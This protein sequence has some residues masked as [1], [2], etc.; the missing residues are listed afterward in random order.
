MK[1]STVSKA[2]CNSSQNPEARIAKKDWSRQ[3][4]R[5]QRRRT[6]RFWATRLM[7]GKRC[8][9][10]KAYR[11]ETGPWP[12]Y[13]GTQGP[14]KGKASRSR[15]SSRKRQSRPL[16]LSRFQSSGFRPEGKTASTRHGPGEALGLQ[17]LASRQ[18]TTGSPNSPGRLRPLS[19]TRHENPSA[20]SANIPSLKT[21]C[22]SRRQPYTESKGPTGWATKRRS[23]GADD[24]KTGQSVSASS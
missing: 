20:P 24:I 21:G 19:P 23:C 5:F 22:P 7:H 17:R 3:R 16:P 1:R 8:G 11:R 9:I 10:E 12:G 13:S 18:L 14:L 15:A 4:G 2:L 6:G